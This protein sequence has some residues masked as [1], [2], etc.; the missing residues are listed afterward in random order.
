MTDPVD[1][2]AVRRSLEQWNNADYDDDAI[3]EARRTIRHV[4]P[5]AD[6]VEAL[7]K[8]RERLDLLERETPTLT[9]LT[10]DREPEYRVVF[11]SGFTTGH[12]LRTAIDLAIGATREEPS[13]E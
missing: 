1:L 11:G 3:V 2:T 9:D 5:L 8:D 10:I 13:D 4:R 12:T 7:R 6:E